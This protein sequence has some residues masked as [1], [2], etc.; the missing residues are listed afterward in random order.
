MNYY[1]LYTKYR[2]LPR[3]ISQLVSIWGQ[4]AVSAIEPK[5]TDRVQWDLNWQ[6]FR[7]IAHSFNHRAPC[8][9]Y[10]TN[11]LYPWN[12]MYIWMWRLVG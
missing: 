12:N 6:L 4:S 7:L 11:N 5:E 3:Y 9:Q 10:V 8:N 2:K 1:L